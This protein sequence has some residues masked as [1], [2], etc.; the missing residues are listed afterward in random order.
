MYIV[1]AGHLRSKYE[2]TCAL[3]VT[4]IVHKSNSTRVDVSM[5]QSTVHVKS[6]FLLNVAQPQLVM[7]MAPVLTAWS[8]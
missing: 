3:H 7:L 8:A 6:T 4:C 1:V 5:R 2:G